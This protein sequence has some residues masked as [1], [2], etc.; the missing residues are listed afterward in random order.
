M[1]R[2][3]ASIAIVTMAGLD[4]LD[5]HVPSPPQ[6]TA[7]GVW[8]VADWSI[9]A[10][11]EHYPF[12]TLVLIDGLGVRRVHDRGSALVGSGPARF[13]AY[14]YSTA[15]ALAWGRR[16]VRYQV[17]WIPPEPRTLGIYP[18]SA[19]DRGRAGE[20]TVFAIGPRRWATA[21]HC[22]AD[23]RRG[24]YLTVAGYF[25]ATW[26]ESMVRDYAEVT[27]P[28]GVTS[29]VTRRPPRAGDRGIALLRGGRSVTLVYA[30]PA[31]WTTENG[32]NVPVAAWCG[33]PIHGGDS[34]SPVYVGETIV[35]IVSI[36]PRA[37]DQQYRFGGC[38]QAVFTTEARRG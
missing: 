36:A 37:N 27:A 23:L 1:F 21:R 20:C 7:S 30:G 34:G 2:L 11:A 8:P 25:S 6:P 10:D 35:G 24:G 5:P 33:G 14:T 31:S 13:D 4:G 26:R 38:R 29:W 18:V 15:D 16:E 32:Q 28:N 19:Y 9:G 22:V 3:F 12:G 17:L